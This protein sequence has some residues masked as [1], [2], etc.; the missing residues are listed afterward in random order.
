MVRII[1]PIEEPMPRKLDMYTHII[2]TGSADAV[3]D[4]SAMTERLVPFVQKVVDKQIPLLGVCYGHQIIAA[5]MNGGTDNIQHFVEP[6]V[7]WT[8]IRRT[9]Q[10]RL[11]N[12]LPKRFWSSENHKSSVVR[13]PKDFRVTASSRRCRIQAM[14]HSSLPI[15]SI[16]F[17]PEHTP[18][19]T[20]RILAYWLA[21]RFPKSWISD[22]SDDTRHY[23][24][25]TLDTILK[26]FYA[27]SRLSD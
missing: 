1:R 25:K 7:G 3:D 10:S 21:K 18:Y 20:K 23:S 11:L 17:H 22:G 14:E 12:E 2:L 15:F 4:V 13:A 8:K 26:N 24:A 6:E 27:V 5:A 19:Q 16:Q 9:G